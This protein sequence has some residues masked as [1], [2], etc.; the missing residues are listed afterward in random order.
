[1]EVQVSGEL[2]S[3]FKK[4]ILGQIV[5]NTGKGKGL[6]ILYT[7][8]QNEFQDWKFKCL[9]WNVKELEEILDDYDCN[10]SFGAFKTE[11]KQ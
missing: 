4:V 7:T 3:Y 2:I 6:F 5:D 1:M 8:H 10:L 9:K 11:Q